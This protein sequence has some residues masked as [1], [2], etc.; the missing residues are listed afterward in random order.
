MGLSDQERRGHIA[1]AI[2]Q[3]VK[4]AEG[5]SHSR[6]PG[7][8]LV[9]QLCQQLWFE[10]LGHQSNGLH[11]IFGSSAVNQISSEGNSLWG[12]ALAE[13]FQAARKEDDWW[14]KSISER[15]K[16]YWEMETEERIKHLDPLQERREE[17]AV[18]ISSLLKHLG[19]EDSEGDELERVFMIY[20]DSETLVYALRR[21]RDQ[22]LKDLAGLDSLVARIQGAC[23]EVFSEKQEFAYCYLVNQILE[24]HLLLGGISPQRHLAIHFG[25]A[26]KI[27]QRLGRY[28]TRPSLDQVMQWHRRITLDEVKSPSQYVEMLY[29]MLG[30]AGTPVQEVDKVAVAIGCHLDPEML[31]RVQK[32]ADSAREAEKGDATKTYIRDRAVDHAYVVHGGAVMHTLWDRERERAGQEEKEEAEERADEEGADEEV[33]RVYSYLSTAHLPGPNCW[34]ESSCSPWVEAKFEGGWFVLIPGNCCDLEYDAP[35]WLRTIVS[36]GIQRRYDGIM[37]SCDAPKVSDLPTFEWP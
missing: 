28:S 22:F 37:F 16:E 18:E 1:F 7:V 2:K 23:F 20:A 32:Q 29:E 12:I 30:S 15:S 14:E 35:E 5:L 3:M 11:W 6:T 36:W 26:S 27:V 31:D 33:R 9:K 13:H 19:Q 8:G 24:H 21:Y 4:R 25:W 10:F 17:A 34:D